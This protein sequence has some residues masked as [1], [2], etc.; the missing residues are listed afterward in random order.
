MPLK[1]E[2]FEV[3]GLKFDY[4]KVALE[5]WKRGRDVRRLYCLPLA[6]AIYRWPL[7]AAP[8]QTAAP[9]QPDLLRYFPGN[10]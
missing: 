5:E 7:I 6:P 3:R 8:P 9:L 2:E 4:E 1:C 10:F